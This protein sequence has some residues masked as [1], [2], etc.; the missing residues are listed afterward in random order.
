MSTVDQNMMTP[1]SI[2]DIGFLT[3]HFVIAYLTL[4]YTVG[5]T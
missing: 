4:L 2:R 3:S 1:I 5:V